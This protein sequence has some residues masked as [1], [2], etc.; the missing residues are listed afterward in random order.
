[1]NMIPLRHFCK[2]TPSGD[3]GRCLPSYQV[4]LTGGRL[5]RAGCSHRTVRQSGY[6]SGRTGNGPLAST[7]VAGHRLSTGALEEVLAS[8]ADVA[9]CAVFGVEDDLKGELPLGM[10]VLK[11]GADRDEEELRRELTALVREK[12]GPVAAFKLVTVVTRLPKTRSGRILRRTMKSIADGKQWKMPATIEDPAVLDDIT[13]S[14][15]RL[16]YP[17]TTPVLG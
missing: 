15:A 12:I 17:R 13:R 9:E 16:G 8:H 1:M 5:S 6:V 10:V 3:L 14:L 11:A 4:S 2:S 7:V